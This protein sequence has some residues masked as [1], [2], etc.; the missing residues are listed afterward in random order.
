MW[1]QSRKYIEKSNNQIVSMI[2]DLTHLQ[3]SFLA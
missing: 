1:L 3:T 2:S